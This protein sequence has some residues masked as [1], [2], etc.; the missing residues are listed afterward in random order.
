MSGLL[1]LCVEM[2]VVAGYDRMR[3]SSHDT[4]IGLIMMALQSTSKSS[5]CIQIGYDPTKRQCSGLYAWGVG[6]GS[7]AFVIPGYKQRLCR[8][9]KRL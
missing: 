2:I 9:A 5:V 3:Q 4:K 1:A 8:R 6:R 7:Q